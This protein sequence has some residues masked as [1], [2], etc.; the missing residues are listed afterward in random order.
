MN[1]LDIINL[2]INPWKLLNIAETADDREIEQA[3]ENLSN[4]NRKNDTIRQAYHLIASEEDRAQFRLLSPHSVED[5]DDIL[6]NLPPRPVY[7][8][9]GIWY[10]SLSAKL[11]KE[12][13]E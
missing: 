9:P 2:R 1:T 6:N 8:G 3:W 7:S 11:K 4:A 5:P 10:K 12:S 13:E